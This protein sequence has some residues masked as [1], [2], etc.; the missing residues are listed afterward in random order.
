MPLHNTI[1]QPI[2]LKSAATSSVPESTLKN[3]FVSI[4]NAEVTSGD[5]YFLVTAKE[6]TWSRSARR[7]RNR[8]D[9]MDIDTE[10]NPKTT[11]ALACRLSVEDKEIVFQWMLGEDRGL[12]EGFCGH[13]SRKVLAS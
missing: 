10:T 3:I 12:F 9:R 6:D 8:T 5:G 13:V 1:R 11:V 2:T 4:S 7:K